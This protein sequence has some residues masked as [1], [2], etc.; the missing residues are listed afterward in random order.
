M[1][2]HLPYLA[3]S[4]G[5]RTRLESSGGWGGWVGVPEMWTSRPGGRRE[6]SDSHTHKNRPRGS[7]LASCRLKKEKEMINTTK[8]YTNIKLVDLQFI[9]RK[10]IRRQ[11]H[12]INCIKQRIIF[13]RIRN[14]HPFRRTS[15]RIP[16][17]R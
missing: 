13:K 10:L 14:T 9:N 16:L 3:V 2:T 11:Y 5:P 4:R 7:E 6:C 12:L 1:W 17:T 15:F 8:K